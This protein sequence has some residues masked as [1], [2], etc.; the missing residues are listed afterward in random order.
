M[1]R[2]GAKWAL[3]QGYAQEEDLQR[4][5]EFGCLEGADTNSVS[6]RAKDRG[7]GQL[8]TLGAGNHF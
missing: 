4:T 5:E 1:C 2:Q 6:K 7:R 3:E 8:G